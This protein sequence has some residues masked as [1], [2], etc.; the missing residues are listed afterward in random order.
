MSTTKKINVHT[1]VSGCTC[2]KDLRIP[3]VRCIEATAKADAK[4]GVK[5]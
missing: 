2:N 4:N 3:D 5:Q 1:H